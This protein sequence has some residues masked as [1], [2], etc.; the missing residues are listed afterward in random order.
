MQT[1]PTRKLGTA[2]ALT[3]TG[4]L[5]L[6]GVA[7][8]TDASTTSSSDPSNDAGHVA[9]D[10]AKTRCLES[11]DVRLTAIGRYQGNVAAAVNLTSDHRASLDSILGS[12]QSGL[13][14]LRATIEAETDPAALK[15]ECSEVFT[16]YRIFALRG[17]QT[18]L[19]IGGDAAAAAADKLAD[20]AADLAEDI[21][22][23]KAAGKD[24]SE[25]EADLADMQAKIADAEAKL[26]G[27]VDTVLTFT[28]AQWNADHTVLSG[29]ISTLRAVRSDLKDAARDARKITVELAD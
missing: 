13:T 4:V 26:P 24:T 18:R 19:S 22:E 29:S 2:A 17:P 6:S 16:G 28:P 5:A 10:A 21:A 20:V 8:A 27:L 7:N 25:A 14:T 1:R 23:A 11:V 3:L 12:A 15:S 9:F